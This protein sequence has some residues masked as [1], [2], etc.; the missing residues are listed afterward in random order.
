MR[1]DV[2]SL[3]GA[4]EQRGWRVLVPQSPLSYEE[5]RAAVSQSRICI[6]PSG[7]GWDCY[8]HYEVLAFGSLPIMNFRPIRSM[9]PLRHG[10][11]CFYFDPQDHLVTQVERCRNTGTN[12]RL[13]DIVAAGQERLKQ[14]Y[15]FDAIA[16][17]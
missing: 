14:H 10:R 17:S 15:T 2:K 9:A 4:L 13:D 3:L 12:E 6:S 5:F 16:D 8:R 1:I 7:I 11:E